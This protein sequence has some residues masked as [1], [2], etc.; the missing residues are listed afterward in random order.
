[1]LPN[2]DVSSDDTQLTPH[3]SVEKQAGMQH[4]DVAGMMK[5]VG[6]KKASVAGWCCYVVHERRQ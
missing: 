5:L 2:H 4:L 6:L 3:R 1:M